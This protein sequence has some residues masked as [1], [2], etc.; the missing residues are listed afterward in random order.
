MTQITHA[1]YNADGS[2]T[3]GPLEGQTWSN[4]TPASRFWSEVQR[5][6][7]AGNTTEPYVKPVDPPI[8]VVKAGWL[9]AALARQDKLASVNAAVSQT[10]Q[11]KQELWEYATE[12]RIDDP[13]I[14]A[15]AAILSID[16]RELF[17]LADQIRRE[18]QE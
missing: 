2:I 12:Y 13:D 3:A 5:W 16:L 15:I 9:R 4:I 14:I 1:K 18:R 7:D 17:D 11:E 8:N 6:V 10:T